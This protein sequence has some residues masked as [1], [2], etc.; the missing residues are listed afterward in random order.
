MGKDFVVSALGVANGLA[1]GE[2]SESLVS[3]PR[4]H[5]YPPP[6]IPKMLQRESKDRLLYNRMPSKQSASH[7]VDARR[8]VTQTS[9]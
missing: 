4:E 3:A 2:D 9:V 8:F 1:R 5:P 6:H 7:I